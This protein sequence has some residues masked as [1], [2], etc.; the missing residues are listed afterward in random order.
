MAVKCAG[1]GKGAT[2]QAAE[3]GPWTS[4]WSSLRRAAGRPCTWRI[5]LLFT[6]SKADMAGPV[7]SGLH[8]SQSITCPNM[9]GSLSAVPL[10]A[11]Q[12]S[13]WIWPSDTNDTWNTVPLA[14]RGP[15][16]GAARDSL[17]EIAAQMDIQAGGRCYSMVAGLGATHLPSGAKTYG[18]LSECS[19]HCS[20]CLCPGEM[21]RHVG[22]QI[23]QVTM[24][25]S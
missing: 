25:G 7:N 15:V 10:A 20:W 24:G 14:V 8:T 17:Q 5:T 11:G 21:R 3:A 6:S 19:C 2:H 12:S 18:A 22:A 23:L 13:H 1:H 9:P 4:G 16:E